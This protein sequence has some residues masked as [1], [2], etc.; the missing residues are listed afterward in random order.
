MMVGRPHWPT[1]FLMGLICLS[2][3]SMRNLFAQ[4][5]GIYML[6]RDQVFRGRNP[7]IP[8]SKNT[9]IGLPEG[10]GILE[11]QTGTGDWLISQPDG[12]RKLSL[13]RGWEGLNRGNYEVN[14]S[15]GLRTFFIGKKFDRFQ[16]G[17]YHEIEGNALVEFNKDLVG[18]LGFGNYG[19]LQ[20]EPLAKEQPLDLEISL[21]NEIFNGFGLQIGYQFN[22]LS[23]GGSLRYLSGLQELHSEVKQLEVDIRDP[24]AI[25]AVEDW[26]VYSANLVNEISLDSIQVIPFN[27]VDVL[28]RHPGLSGSLG[29][30]YQSTQA[31]F[32][33]QWK[34]IGNIHWK[35]GNLYSRNVTTNYSGIL[36]PNLLNIDQNVFNSI[37]DT[38]KKIST[39]N[40]APQNYRT[41]LRSNILAEFQYTFSNK[42]TVG[43]AVN[44]YFNRQ[45]WRAMAGINY[46]LLEILTLGS[47][48]S[49]HSSGRLNMGIHAALRLYAFNLFLNTDHIQSLYPTDN[50]NRL[51]ARIGISLMW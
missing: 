42:W 8:F 25:R 3:L 40:Q 38:L 4:D 14:V 23:F 7:A 35:D 49:Y 30:S 15:W 16:I 27:E 31:L 22:K 28:G 26:K 43:S 50:I 19:Y 2:N 17:I 1:L 11:R 10:N 44:Y 5:L 45:Q 13:S 34:D 6:S 32:A 48:F 29:L 9:I 37:G 41:Y 51:S 20:K 21:K 33:I 39:V 18:I 46:Q 47:Q 12:S 24:L 36:V